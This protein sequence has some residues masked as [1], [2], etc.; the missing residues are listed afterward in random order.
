MESVAAGSCQ[1]LKGRAKCQRC[2]TAAFYHFIALDWANGG[3][4]VNRTWEGWDVKALEASCYTV[5][6]ASSGCSSYQNIDIFL[7]N[8][9]P[10]LLCLFFSICSVPLHFPSLLCEWV[11]FKG[12][13]KTVSYSS[14]DVDCFLCRDETGLLSIWFVFASFYMSWK[15]DQLTWDKREVWW[16]WGRAALTP[17]CHTHWCN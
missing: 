1:P 15:C 2:L 4:G 12:R 9:F 3:G 8:S 17:N 5:V 13:G 7:M 11:V 14:W 6:H 16:G 10:S